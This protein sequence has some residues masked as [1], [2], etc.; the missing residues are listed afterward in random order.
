MVIDSH[1]ADTR[2]KDEEFTSAYSVAQMWATQQAG[3]TAQ[4]SLYL[5]GGNLLDDGFGSC[6][7]TDLVLTDNY[8]YNQTVILHFL[9][10]AYG[11][12]RTVVVVPR[13]L[14]EDTGHSDV[15]I[16]LYGPRRAIVGFYSEAQRR[17]DTTSAKNH[18]LMQDTVQRLKNMG[19]FH[20]DRMPM[21]DRTGLQ[22]RERLLETMDRNVVPSYLN[23]VILS[24]TVVM[25]AFDH[26]SVHE[27]DAAEVF[28]DAYPGRSVVLVDASHV[29]SMGGG[30]RCITSVIPLGL[31]AT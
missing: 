8:E 24:E 15:F 31:V 27:H 17:A 9:Q 10:V 2:R 26:D 3:P 13:L 28:R 4:S 23:A 5:D 30:L 19:G 29:A 1:Y 20:V 6:V 22:L 16:H 11:C 14:L 12:Y 21:P 18:A 7:V 25:P